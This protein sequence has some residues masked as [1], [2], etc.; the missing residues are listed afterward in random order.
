MTKHI[1]FERI[2]NV[3]NN[4]L[5]KNVGTQLEISVVNSEYYLYVL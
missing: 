3:N 5:E 4:V 1:Q 2:L